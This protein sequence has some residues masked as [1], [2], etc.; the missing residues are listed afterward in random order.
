MRGERERGNLLGA[1]SHGT[2]P[3]EAHTSDVAVHGLVGSR[4]RELRIVSASR[5]QCAMHRHV[6]DRIGQFTSRV[7]GAVLGQ[8]SSVRPVDEED[9]SSLVPVVPVGGW[10]SSAEAE[11]SY[12]PQRV[13]MRPWVSEVGFVERRPSEEGMPRWYKH[14]RDEVEK[15]KAARADSPSR[16]RK[17]RRSRSVPQASRPTSGSASPAKRSRPAVDAV[18]HGDSRGH[19][20]RVS[21]VS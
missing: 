5:P 15:A 2:G 21:P 11:G 1:R 6:V 18:K 13:S 3:E 7:R 17:E 10:R 19:T 12:R 4:P 14:M 20:R 16:A 8:R 9:F